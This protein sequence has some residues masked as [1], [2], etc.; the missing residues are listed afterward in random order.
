MDSNPKDLSCPPNEE[1]AECG[2]ACEPKCNEPQQNIC[3]EECI[4][5]V[6]E[7][8]TGYKRATNGT[9]VKIGPDCQ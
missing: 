6:C 8:V 2:K 7:C 3:T 9:C 4:E 5:N 1:P